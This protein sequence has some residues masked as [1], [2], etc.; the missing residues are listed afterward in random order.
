MFIYD[1]H[2][3]LKCQRKIDFELPKWSFLRVIPMK[4][5]HVEVLHSRCLILVSCLIL[6]SSL[7]ISIIGAQSPDSAIKAGLGKASKSQTQQS[8]QRLFLIKDFKV[9]IKNERTIQLQAGS[10]VE[11]LERL[12]DE[13]QIRIELFNQQVTVPSDHL[14][15]ASNAESLLRTRALS[16]AASSK[17][18]WGRFLLEQERYSEAAEVWRAIAMRSETNPLDHYLAVRACLSIDQYQ[19]AVLALDELLTQKESISQASLQ[20]I[21]LDWGRLHGLRGRCHLKT[22]SL[23]MAF[24]DFLNAVDAA[25]NV[26][27]HRLD[28]FETM[29]MLNRFEDAMS[30]EEA[31]L[32]LADSREE[33]QKS[34]DDRV[35]KIVNHVFDAN[36]ANGRATYWENRLLLL[37]ERRTPP[38]AQQAERVVRIF[39]SANQTERAEELLLKFQKQYPDEDRFLLLKADRANELGETEA[40]IDLYSQILQEVPELTEARS[41]RARLYYR[42]EDF[43]SAVS[44][45]RKL[46]EANPDHPDYLRETGICLLAMG[47]SKDGL[48]CFRRCTKQDPANHR[49]WNS[50][51][52]LLATSPNN[53]IRNA[54]EA[55]LSAQKACE[56]TNHQVAAYLDT[57]AASYAE[58]GKFEEAVSA[59]IDAIDRLS[60]IE[61]SL[62]PEF[63]DRLKRYQNKKTY[64]EDPRHPDYR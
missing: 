35:W 19:D 64:R 56:L 37:V 11:V 53:E 52:W 10:A 20:N 14:E 28:L 5:T 21:G 12:A 26:I 38:D 33:I 61:Q 9:T 47:K 25:P 24:Q 13:K 22:G 34:L 30:Q 40:A 39:L 2:V 48:E 62:R 1:H 15:P 18:P 32:E 4:F 49:A 23:K 54:E 55:I 8:D 51:A 36:P 29:L 50:S 46:V 17:R 3:I 60:L 45:F 16:P 41:R 6:T 57:L 59:Q 27:S 58:A 31:I 44:E 63:Q 42:V 7:K 43:E